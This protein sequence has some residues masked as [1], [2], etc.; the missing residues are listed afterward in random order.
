MQISCLRSFSSWL[1]LLLPIAWQRTWTD[2]AAEWS[3]IAFLSGLLGIA[4]LGSF[5]FAVHRLT[6]ARRTPCFLRR[7]C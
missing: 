5:V 4:M 6:L 1:L 3:A 7:R 2:A